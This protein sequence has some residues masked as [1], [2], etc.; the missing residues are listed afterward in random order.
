MSA[1][2]KVMAF[3]GTR[4]ELIKME[5][6]LRELK[7]RPGVELFFVHTGQHYDYNMSAVFIKELALPEPDIYLGVKVGLPGEQIARVVARSERVLRK[8]RPD[9][10]MVLGDTHSALGAAIAA[11]KNG[12]AVGHVE[13]GCRSFEREMPEE[14]N[15]VLIA[16]LATHN[17]AP[18]PNCQGNL[19]REGIAADSIHLTGHPIVDLLRRM[20]ER[21][22]DRLIRKWD[23]APGEYYLVTAH[24]KDNVETAEKLRGI[25][26]AVGELSERKK[27]IFPVHPRTLKE[28]KRRH[29]WGLLKNCIVTEPLGYMES[30]ALIRNASAVLTD[31]G[32]IQ[33]EAAILGTPCIT[34]RERT[35]WVETV[36]AGV[37]ILAGHEA[38]RILSAVA[39]S[40]GGTGRSQGGKRAAAEL[41]GKF[42]V[43]PRIAD[44]IESVGC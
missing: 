35:E 37:N 16:D 34:L 6:V 19:L 30:L 33:Q 20:A 9:M 24:R 5:P 36:K 3:V 23:L 15:R 7:K 26:T 4:P 14:Q 13:A 18:T 1:R 27:A 25:L 32:G 41:F 29:L 2:I 21:L 28:I 43:A 8:L 39:S 17:F 12:V 10:A 42:P 38:S 31:S 44:E 22:D 40:K 11:A